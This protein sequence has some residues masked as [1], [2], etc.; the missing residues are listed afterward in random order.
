MHV[1][2]CAMQDSMRLLLATV[3]AVVLVVGCNKGGGRPP[4]PAPP[5]PLFIGEPHLGDLEGD[6]DGELRAKC[7]RTLTKANCGLYLG[8]GPLSLRDRFNLAWRGCIGNSPENRTS[9]PMKW[10]HNL[11]WSVDERTCNWLAS[12]KFTYEILK[13]ELGMRAGQLELVAQLYSSLCQNV[14]WAKKD[15]VCMAAVLFRWRIDGDAKRATGIALSAC[16]DR[17]VPEVCGLLSG[18]RSRPSDLPPDQLVAEVPDAH[19]QRILRQQDRDW[20]ERQRDLAEREAE[21]LQT[22]RIDDE[23]RAQQRLSDEEFRGR[24]E[25]IPASRQAAPSPLGTAA[26]PHASPAPT[27]TTKCPSA[28]P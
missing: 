6:R 7:R 17:L 21:R 16:F 23:F 3:A 25:A 9:T 8:K 4:T 26:A 5:A 20:E 28:A 11:V 14:S 18:G 1:V 10:G 2:G 12:E 24:L 13:R 27:T 15:S 22:Q 19:W